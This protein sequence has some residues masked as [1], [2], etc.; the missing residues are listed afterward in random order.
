MQSLGSAGT[1]AVTNRDQDREVQEV[2]RLR[3]DEAQC[4]VTLPDDRVPE[5]VNQETSDVAMKSVQYKLQNNAAQVNTTQHLQ[6]NFV[7][8][9]P[10]MF[11]GV[12]FKY[13]R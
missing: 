12:V 6:V 13:E 7:G 2:Y 1:L 11:H 3:A 10:H 4:I 9:N 5:L 8:V